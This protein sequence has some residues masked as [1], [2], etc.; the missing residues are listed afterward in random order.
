MEK[1]VHQAVD[2]TRQLL[3]VLPAVVLAMFGGIAKLLL[4]KE[5]IT[6]RVLISSMFVSGFVGAVTGFLIQ[7]LNLHP[8]YSSFLCAMSGHSAGLVL[9]VYQKKVESFLEK[10]GG[11][12]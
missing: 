5:T 11:K 3:E 10:V 1:I 6:F 4:G 7:P 12:E 2:L 9:F 8:G